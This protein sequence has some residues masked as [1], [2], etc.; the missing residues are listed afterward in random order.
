MTSEEFHQ[1]M[2]NITRAERRY[3]SSETRIRYIRKDSDGNECKV[4]EV[5]EDEKS[6]DHIA[7]MAHADSF[8]TEVRIEKLEVKITE[9]TWDYIGPE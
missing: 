3:E 8:K 4:M 5:L 7:E 2:E 1:N 9:V 6:W